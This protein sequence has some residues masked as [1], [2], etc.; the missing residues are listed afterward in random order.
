MFMDQAVVVSTDVQRV[1]DSTYGLAGPLIGSQADFHA[2]EAQGFGTA[3]SFGHITRSGKAELID[4]QT[5]KITPFSVFFKQLLGSH[6]DQ[7][8]ESLYDVFAHLADAQHGEDR[9]QQH[10]KE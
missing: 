3:Q 7:N 5:H 9:R 6:Y 2:V 8:N 4:S 10:H 1:S